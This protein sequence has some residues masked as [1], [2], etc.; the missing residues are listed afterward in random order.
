MEENGIH[1]LHQSAYRR[2]HSTETALVLRIHNGIS[3]AISSHRKVTLV[4]LDLSAAFDSLN[5]DIFVD[6]L[7]SI[8][9]SDTTLAWFRSYL[10]G[11]SIVRISNQYT[12]ASACTT[13]VLQGSVIG[14]L[15]FTGYCLSFADIITKH[16][17]H[18]HMYEDDTQLY[19]DFPVQRMK[20]LLNV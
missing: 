13:G 10:S 14:P 6:R 15:L 20:F 2:N 18:F 4:L 7:R 12:A 11:T 1:A 8:G 9:L 5:H 3:R 16:G 19:I 17:V